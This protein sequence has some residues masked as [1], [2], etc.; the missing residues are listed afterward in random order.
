MSTSSLREELNVDN[1]LSNI[2]RK[3]QPNYQE[4]KLLTSKS[5]ILNT[6][7]VIQLYYKNSKCY[8]LLIH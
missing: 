6:G 3:K 4:Q 1:F 7:K 8:R 5:S 2:D